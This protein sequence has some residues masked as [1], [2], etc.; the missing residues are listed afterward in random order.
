MESLR[1]FHISEEADIPLFR[2]RPS[3]SFFPRIRGDAVFAISA[4]LLHN[5]LLPRDCPRVTW[6]A[7]TATTPSDLD[8]WMGATSA[9]FVMAVE[10]RWYPAIV[11]T[12]LHCYEFPVAGFTILDETAG[13]YISYEPVT[14]LAVREI[15][16]IPEELFQR[17]VELRFLPD[18]RKLADAIRQSSLSFSLI[19]MRNAIL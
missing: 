12:K 6:Y 5:Y 15:N 1:L 4:K 3:P 11:R 19:R 7:N 2:P 10:T 13:Y 16:D 8:K 9:E 17:N 14:P 18:L